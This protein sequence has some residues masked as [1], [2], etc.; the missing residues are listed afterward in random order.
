MVVPGFIALLDA[1]DLATVTIE[2][3]L[4]WAQQAPTSSTGRVT[5]VGPRRTTVVRGLARY[6]AGIDAST[7]C[8]RRG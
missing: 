6:L 5:T 4:A 2:A 7:E 1:D 3:A 8:R